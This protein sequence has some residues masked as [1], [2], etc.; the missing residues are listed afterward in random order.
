MISLSPPLLPQGNIC[1]TF[2]TF[3]FMH[4]SSLAAGVTLSL[5]QSFASQAVV[6][7]RKK[8]VSVKSDWPR[9]RRERGQED[10]GAAGDGRGW[11]GKS[12][13]FMWWERS[14]DW[15]VGSLICRPDRASVD[16]LSAYK[17][18]SLDLAWLAIYTLGVLRLSLSFLL[19]PQKLPVNES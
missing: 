3:Q 2:V 12:D 16:L 13:L 1:V 19:T 14:T 10:L 15:W 9:G 6:I 4:N 11:A 8:Y 5:M 18:G 7:P 17:A